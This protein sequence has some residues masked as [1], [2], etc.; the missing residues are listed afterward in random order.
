MTWLDEASSA[1]RRLN[2]VN[3]WLKPKFADRDDALD[4]LTLALLCHEHIL[5]IGEPGTAKSNICDL[6]ARQIGG[7]QH[8]Y[9]LLTRF[10]EPS[11]IFGPID[12]NRFTAGEYRLNTAN[13]L[14]EAEI[15]FLDEV[16]EA[17]SAILNTLLTLVNE[18]KYFDGPEVKRAK[19]I[20]LI[21]ASNGLPED[22]A[23]AAFSDRFLLRLVVDPVPIENLSELLKLGAENEERAESGS[24]P[25]I[26][27]SEVAGLHSLLPRVDLSPVSKV[28][29]KIMRDLSLKSVA[30]SDRRK[31]KGQKLVRGAAM[32]READHASE[33][34]LWP[35]LHIWMNREDQEQVR[36]ALT[37]YVGADASQRGRKRLTRDRAIMRLREI[38]E[39]FTAASSRPSV[40]I[41]L[42][43]LNKLR[44]DVM[45][46]I[47]D[48]DLREEVDRVIA[49]AINRLSGFGD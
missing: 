22:A 37:P 10:T 32:L 33:E 16:F 46:E 40:I 34:D 24:L 5:L 38:E 42:E 35:L 19:L 43:Q 7:C 30:L 12:I 49:R 48:D 26:D 17:S 44:T 2:K 13:M 36:E 21:G 39:S 8:F 45:V 25:L 15:A 28:Y 29:E 4:L 14:P 20:T 47:N 9:Y 41:C 3:T 27:A 1:I 31:I 11:E 23:L 18:R 6:F